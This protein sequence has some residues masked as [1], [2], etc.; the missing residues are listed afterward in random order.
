M[1]NKF[2]EERFKVNSDSEKKK[3]LRYAEQQRSQL[4]TEPRN[5]D[6]LYR[7]ALTYWQLAGPWQTDEASEFSIQASSNAKE[8]MSFFSRAA[9]HR[10]PQIDFLLDFSSFLEYYVRAIDDSEACYFLE[11]AL[12]MLEDADLI[13]PGDFQIHYQMGRKHLTK[14]TYLLAKEQKKETLLRSIDEFKIALS[15]AAVQPDCLNDMADAYLRLGWAC[16]YNCDENY[17]IAVDICNQAITIEQNPQS[18]CFIAEAYLELYQ[19]S[20]DTADL[21]NAK[22]YIDIANALEDNSALGQLDIYH[23]LQL[24]G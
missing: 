13:L 11:L 8:A 16:R 3:L 19:L 14:S 24:N 10:P 15:L 21:E 20:N 18:N 12:I 9:N 4:C 23:S 6:V 1:S 7:L 22:V 2:I 5:F 17:R